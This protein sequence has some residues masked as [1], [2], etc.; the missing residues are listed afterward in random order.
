MKAIIIGASSGMGKELAKILAK[1]KY[2]L[3]LAARRT[4]LLKELKSELDTKSFVKYIDVSKTDEAMNNLSELIKEMKDVDLIIITSG[5]GYINY[6]LDWSKE[7]ETIDINVSGVTSMINIAF[8]YFMK[9]Q[10]GHLVVLSSIAALKGNNDS[11]AYSA[12]KA[13]LANYLE[14]LRLKIKKDKLNITI[15]DIRPGLVDTDM[16]KGEGLFWV[17]PV[18]KTAKQIYISIKKEKS[19][20][21]YKKM[22]TYCIFNEMVLKIEFDESISIFLNLNHNTLIAESITS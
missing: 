21:C 19:C 17:Q 20:L 1:E 12:S 6:E 10:S 22:E 18:D 13:F 8:K 5:T 16:A 4:E 7:K 9:K 14:G 15:T 11:P 3:G 2:E